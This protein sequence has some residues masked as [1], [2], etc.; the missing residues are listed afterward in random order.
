MLRA[1]SS[2]DKQARRDAITAAALD[3]F[4]DKGFTAAR[5]DDIAARAGVSKAA[6]Y[7]YFDSKD[8]L[9]TALVEDYA[10]PQIE[11]LEAAIGAAGGGLAAIDAALGL[12][13]YLIRESPMPKFMKILVGS[14][15][16]FADT[17][18]RYRRTV[19]DRVFSLIERNLTAAAAAGEIEIE[20]AGLTTRLVVAPIVMSALWRVVFEHDPAA[21]FDLEKL[22]SLHAAMMRRAL[23]AKKAA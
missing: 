4:Y 22:L 17:V 13:P 23:G 20:D 12:I 8:A 14:A 19:I 6:I 1:R 9:F 15:P 3:E 2:E 18:T 16:A 11:R 10:V 5:M 21:K 7:L